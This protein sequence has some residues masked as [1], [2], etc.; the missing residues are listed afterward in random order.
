M[1][2]IVE[3]DYELLLLVVASVTKSVCEWESESV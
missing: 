3:K 2:I 1:V